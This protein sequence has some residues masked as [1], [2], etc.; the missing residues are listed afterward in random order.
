MRR[1]NW[2]LTFLAATAV[3]LSVAC[4]GGS[5]DDPSPTAVAGT[6]TA[7]PEASCAT[8][9]PRDA[10]S[11]TETVQSG[12]AE[13]SYILHVPP[14]YD[15]SARAPL[16]VAFHGL[17]QPA[18]LLASQTDIARV[19]DAAG[20]LLVLPT[21]ATIN[22]GVAAVSVW[23]VRETPAGPDD[24]LFVNDLLA[25]VGEQV[26]V[27]TSN[28]FAMGFSNGG[29]MTL[30][31]SCKEPERFAAIG[32]VAATFPGCTADVPMVA[33][34]GT[35]DP[36]VPFEGG[37]NPPERGGGLFPPIRR[38]VSE[39]ARAGGCGGLPT[40]TKSGTDIELST[41]T[42][43]RGAAGD[44]LLYSILGGGHTWPGG[45][46]LPGDLVGRTTDSIDASERIVEFFEAHER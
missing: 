18:D 40:I 43:C 37:E 6:P 42:A 35:D 31:A 24:S 29:G 30:L 25:D 17:S 14:G 9:L 33:F 44:V 2:T 21:A 11:V 20:Y 46:A 39:W 28:V 36:I 23:N 4:G 5:D 16:V 34:H 15:G 32:V 7:A 45:V 19:T 27:D 26:C 41:F 10:G 22:F 8:P 3:A 1:M 13:R 12:G 38:S